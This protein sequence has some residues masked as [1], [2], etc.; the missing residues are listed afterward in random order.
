VEVKNKSEEVKRF[1]GWGQV[2]PLL[3]RPGASPGAEFTIYFKVYLTGP[4]PT[5]ERFRKR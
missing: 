1:E 5:G 3:V 2:Q 4:I